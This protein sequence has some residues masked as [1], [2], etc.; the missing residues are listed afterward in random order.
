VSETTAETV[1]TPEVDDAPESYTSES[2]SE[3]FSTSTPREI[4]MA[5]GA[6]TRRRKEANAPVRIVTG[7]GHWTINRPALDV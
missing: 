3:S 6:A 4:V 2:T 1:E 7:S 5:P